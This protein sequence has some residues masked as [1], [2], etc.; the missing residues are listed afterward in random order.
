M[1]PQFGP[2]TPLSAAPPSASSAVPQRGSGASPSVHGTPAPSGHLDT[3]PKYQVIPRADG[4]PPQVV[5]GHV[6]TVAGLWREY[7]HGVDGQPSIESLDQ[8]WGPSWRPEPKDRTWYSRRKLVWDKMKDFLHDDL[9]E[10]QAVAE[11]ERIRDGRSLNW[12]MN[13]LQ[14]NRKE[15]KRSWRE[16]AATARAAKKASDE[17]RSSSRYA[18]AP[19]SAA[20]PPGTQPPSNG[21]PPS[22]I[23]SAGSALRPLA[24]GFSRALDG[25]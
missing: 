5:Y 14:N 10:E 3:I 12:L 7:R 22:Q 25:R 15:A 20:S 6:G 16:A 17:S 9:S 13:L 18:Y 23:P 21:I 2:A 8:T 4:K 11:V 24:P 1:R 19:L